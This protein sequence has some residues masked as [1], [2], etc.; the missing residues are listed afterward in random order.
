VT[1]VANAAVGSKVTEHPRLTEENLSKTGRLCSVRRGCSVKT[2]ALIRDARTL[3]VR[4]RLCACLYP[5][6]SV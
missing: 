1:V 4:R 6:V 3:A 2:E 5:F